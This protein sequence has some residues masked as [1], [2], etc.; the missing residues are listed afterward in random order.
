MTMTPDPADSKAAHELSPAAGASF[1]PPTAT[2]RSVRGTETLNTPS[3]RSSLPSAPV[4][5]SM[6]AESSAAP[7]AC[8]TAASNT[9]ASG[10]MQSIDTSSFQELPF[11]ASMESCLRR[12]ARPGPGSKCCSG[13]SPSP[14]A[15]LPASFC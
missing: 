7:W 4:S 1:T 14:P 15:F 12:A 13:P 9:A 8:G 3:L 5:C 2:A 10:I 11:R 6:R